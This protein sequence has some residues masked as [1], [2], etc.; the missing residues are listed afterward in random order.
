MV[1]ELNLVQSSG[2]MFGE[3]GIGTNVPKLTRS[4]NPIIVTPLSYTSLFS[5]INGYGLTAISTSK[6]G[7]ANQATFIPFYITE[8]DIVRKLLALNG[9][10]IAGNIDVGIYADRYDGKVELV[11]S[12]GG[13]AQSGSGQL[14][15]LSCSGGPLKISPGRYYL[16]EA[17]SNNTAE[18]QGWTVSSEHAFKAA[19]VSIMA[20]AYPLPAVATL[21]ALPAGVDL[22]F[23]GVSFRDLVA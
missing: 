2:P 5:H 7:V 19:G 16:A 9:T 6:G 13:S 22:P 23:I 15:E 11:V 21:A 20:S 10:T 1:N 3:F 18:L 14:Q 8:T 4:A 12:N 17:R